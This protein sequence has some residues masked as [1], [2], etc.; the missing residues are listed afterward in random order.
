MTSSADYKTTSTIAE[1]ITN[2]PAQPQSSSINAAGKMTI[3][4]QLLIQRTPEENDNNLSQYL[5]STLKLPLS[6][7]KRV[8]YTDYGCDFCQNVEYGDLNEEQRQAANEAIDSYMQPLPRAEIIKLITRLQIISPEKEKPEYDL[9]ARLIIWVEELVN[10][11]ADIVKSALTRRYRWFPALA[12]VLEFCDNEIAF[13][14]L[15][16]MGLN[17]RRNDF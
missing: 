14:K 6:T 3:T 15:L 9:K 11:P 8:C 16:K 1:T 7:T 2:S 12:E 5:K 10:Y 4:P 17:V 13:R